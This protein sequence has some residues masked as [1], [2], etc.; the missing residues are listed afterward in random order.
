MPSLGPF[1]TVGDDVAVPALIAIVGLCLALG[2]VLVPWAVANRRRQ[3]AATAAAAAGLS[4]SAPDPFDCTRIAF[5][6]FRKGDGRTAENV[7]WREGAELASRAFDFSY[8][9]LH[10]DDMGREH[11]TYRHFSCAMVQVD[12]SWPDLSIGPDGLLEKALDLV[13]MGSID[14]ESDEFNRRFAL[15]SPDRRFAVALCDAGMIDFLLGCTNEIAFAIKGRWALL[16][17]DPVS[18]ALLP[19][20]LRLAEDFRAHIPRVVYELY[21]SP[22]RDEHGR[23]LPAGDEGL[24]AREAVESALDTTGGPYDALVPDD[25]P[26][27]DL[28]GHVVPP[29]VE[30]PWGNH[31]KPLPDDDRN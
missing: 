22:F 7:V 8:Y 5:P 26:E 9:D 12:G 4:F 18:P 17:S 2:L 15:R 11:R 3:D 31:E 27:Y 21:P 1:A 20:L 25:G 24:G 16:A 14:L 6:L 19:A 13:G 28:D 10:K 30:D 29:A 23:P